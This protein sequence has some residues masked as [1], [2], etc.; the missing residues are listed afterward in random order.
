[1]F[2]FGHKQMEL[3]YKSRMWYMY[4][5][6]LNNILNLRKRQ[7]CA[8][9]RCSVHLHVATVNSANLASLKIM[10]KN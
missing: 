3:H 2:C 5:C 6:F 9:S 1:M 7:K 4:V 10:C 8:I